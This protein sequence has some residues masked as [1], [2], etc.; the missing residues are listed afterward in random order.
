MRSLLLF[1]LYINL[2][3]TVCAPKTF[4]SLVQAQLFGVH[5]LRPLFLFCMA[6]PK[7][8]LCTT[9]AFVIVGMDDVVLFYPNPVL[10]MILL[11]SEYQKECELEPV[12]QLPSLAQFSLHLKM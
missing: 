1:A 4:G 5:N 7:P 12:K 8:R 11:L 10:K 3:L 9:F 2:F 6:A